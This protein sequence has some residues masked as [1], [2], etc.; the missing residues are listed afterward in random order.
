MDDFKL[1][2][3]RILLI[4]NGHG[5]D[6]NS[7]LIGDALSSVKPNLTVDAFPIV[8]EGKSY[9]KK[10]IKIVAH[11]KS[12][13]SGGIFYLNIINLI[14]DLFSGLI[15][16]TI[17]QIITI[18]KIKNNYDLVIAVGDIVPLFFAYLTGK[19]YISFLVANS[20]YYEGKLK[21]PFLTKLLL[22]SNRCQL[23]FAKDK[24]TAQDLQNQGFTKTICVGYPI[25]DDLKPTGKNLELCSEKTMIALLP[26]SRLP[27]ALRNFSL[28]LAVCEKLVN[29]S[30]ENWQFLGAL[31][32]TITEEDLSNIEGWEYDSGVLSKEIDG[33]HI[34]VKV[35]HDA[36][37]DI[38]LQCNLVL[39]M[40]G[41]AVEQAVGLG[42]PV[43]QIPGKGPQFTYRFAEAQMRLL[44]SSTITMEE[45]KDNQVMCEKTA[46]KIIEVLDDREFLEQCVINGKERI[47]TTGASLAMA[48]AIIIKDLP[49]QGIRKL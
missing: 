26:G 14:K 41:T 49:F 2:I 25:M 29:I 34:T 30:S 10:G 22:R 24:Y 15:G 11:L 31:V 1:K 12:M 5:E 45:N 48:K 4:S 8:G 46:Y 21:L 38:L 28:Q 3:T 18:T 9:I 17:Q 32:P 19:K 13:P 44:G 20:S 37:A 43:I 23:I 33:K 6:L 16:L 35:Y 47:G 7:S 36:F 39:G 42:K 27:E 40:A